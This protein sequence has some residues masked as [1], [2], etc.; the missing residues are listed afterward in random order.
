MKCALAL[1][2]L[3]IVGTACAGPLLPELRGHTFVYGA[4][5][6][7]GLF[8]W[9]CNGT[10]PDTL[11]FTDFSG[12]REVTGYWPA[13]PNPP[14]Y[15]VFDLTGNNF[16]GD[17][18]LGVKFTG[19]DAP[20]GTLDVSLVGSGISSSPNDPDLSIFG[21][22]TIGAQVYQGLLWAVH[23]DQVSLYGFS[24]RNSYVLEGVG[25]IVDGQLAR[26]YNLVGQ[27]GAMRGHL[28]FVDPPAG[29][30]PPLYNPTSDIQARIRADYTGATGLVPEAA[31][32]MLLV[33]GLFLRRR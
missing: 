14:V 26:A 16:G 18:V 31:S 17:F 13:W 3:G 8:E 30:I 4:H 21:T 10:A 1:V 9:G 25:T 6:Q 5:N 27:P 19:Q 24:G 22:V 20:I 28:D 11:I 33:A 23:L 15:P 12:D 29:W 32:L 2:V 7:E